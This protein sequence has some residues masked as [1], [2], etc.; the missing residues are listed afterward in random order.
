MIGDV[1]EAGLSRLVL[2]ARRNGNSGL[3]KKEG[4]L[5]APCPASRETGWQAS[6]RKP[7]EAADSRQFSALSTAAIRDAPC[8]PAPRQPRGARDFDPLQRL[9]LRTT[10]YSP[11]ARKAGASAV[12][13][14]F[15]AATGS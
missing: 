12:K 1:L 10:R 8:A 7:L 4:G 11:A 9:W 14:F 15:A 6:R 3:K 5:Q 13:D 2:A